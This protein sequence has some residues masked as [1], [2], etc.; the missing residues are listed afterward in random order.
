VV[1]GDTAARTWQK[2]YPARPRLGL[3]ECYLA[4]DHQVECYLARDHQAESYPVCELCFRLEPSWMEPELRARGRTTRP[5]LMNERSPA[6][7]RPTTLH[8]V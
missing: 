5:V 7:T 6:R 1:K 2:R 3:V 4:R 8:F